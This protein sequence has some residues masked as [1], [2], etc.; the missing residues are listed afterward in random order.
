MDKDTNI[1]EQPQP[2]A[3]NDAAKG[4]VAALCDR[5]GLD[6]S[7]YRSFAPK[8]IT[9]QPPSMNPSPQPPDV[10]QSEAR[11][12]SE[13]DLK[14]NVPLRIA[15]LR[16]STQGSSDFAGE[17]K[18][19]EA[20]EELRHTDAPPV[21]G[22]GKTLRMALR[23]PGRTDMTKPRSSLV[24]SDV[25]L[26]SGDRSFSA[27]R[28]VFKNAMDEIGQTTVQNRL[29]NGSVAVI[30]MDGGTGKTTVCA[31]L[32]RALNGEGESVLL[33]D[34]VE[35]SVLPLYF[36]AKAVRTGSIHSFMMP[37]GHGFAPL[38]LYADDVKTEVRE[39]T[40]DGSAKLSRLRETMDLLHS[41]VDRAIVD[42]QSGSPWRSLA[43]LQASTFNLIVIVPDLLS[44]MSVA[45][46]EQFIQEQDQEEI[47]ISRPF[48]L[49]NKFDSARQLHLEIRDRMAQLVGNRL[50]PVPIRFSHEVAEAL[51]AGTTVIDYVPH[52]G[53]VADFYSLASWLR[54]C[55]T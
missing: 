1:L 24:S 10:A 36:G 11:I 41:N 35:E 54:Y 30:G 32:A 46:M 29:P 25:P 48:Y 5:A 8:R 37:N 21:V 34:F 14:A 47:P 23:N 18:V 45:R 39:A 22:R 13:E 38:H 42:T 17:R 4:D 27:L 15:E 12:G 52:A 53:V 26:G 40:G 55:G 7:K 51:A 49:L 50:L 2:T 6:S 20:P 44:A 16:S 28:N 43:V 9:S 3:D 31:T 33:A 19:E